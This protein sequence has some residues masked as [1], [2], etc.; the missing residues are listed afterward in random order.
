MVICWIA[1]LLALT[2]CAPPTEVVDVRQV[3]QATGDAMVHVKILP[4]GMPAPPGVGSIS[5]I[6][7]YACAQTREA[8]SSEAVRQLQVKALSL[9]ATAV[10]NVLIGAGGETSCLLGF[11]MLA[12]GTA[13]APRGIPSSY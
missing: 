11:G 7:G 12:N 9:H 3:P 5:P 8:A 10:V 6:S 1:G 4:L 13:V 2:R